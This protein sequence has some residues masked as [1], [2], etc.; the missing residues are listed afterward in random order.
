MDFKIIDW[1][2]IVGYIILIFKMAVDAAKSVSH[3]SE[4]SPISIGEEKYLAGKSLT[5]TESI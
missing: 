2:V 5:F 3:S 1:I 4:T